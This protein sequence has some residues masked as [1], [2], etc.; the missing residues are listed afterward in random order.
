[1]LVMQYT[2]Q[3]PD[4]YDMQRIRKRVE[5]RCKLFENLPGLSHKSYLMHDGDK[6]YAP[7][8]V[9]SDAAAARAFMLE[10]LFRGVIDEFSRPRV[11]TWMPVSSIHGNRAL[12]PLYARREAD[13]I[14]PETNLN[15]LMDEERRQQAALQKNPDLYFHLVALDPDR[16]ELM[17]Y[18]MW[19]T[20][21]KAESQ[22]ADCVQDYEVI[23]VS[24]G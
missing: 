20:R 21:V 1:M 7:L 23:Y 10:H 6:I 3:L 2:I 4:D 8:Y 13:V 24:E 22:H 9:W 16:W 17:R 15:A 11:R 18:S 19:S 14:A 5:D 12:T